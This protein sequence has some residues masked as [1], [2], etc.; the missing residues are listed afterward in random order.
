MRCRLLRAVSFIALSAFPL[1]GCRTVAADAA[2]A[3]VGQKAALT[4]AA[5]ELPTP[6][7]QNA[8]WSSPTG[9]DASG[10]SPELIA[11]VPTLFAQGL[12]DPRS[13]AYQSITVEVGDVWSGRGRVCWKRTAGFS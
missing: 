4:A 11:A 10:F 1:A 8:P 6:P 2:P 12:A 5:S 9:A 3:A 13:G 7:Q